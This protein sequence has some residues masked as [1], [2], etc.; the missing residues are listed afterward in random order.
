M[1]MTEADGPSISHLK[2]AK[3]IQEANQMKPVSNLLLLDLNA[4]NEFWCNSS[5]L[6]RILLLLLDYNFLGS[7]NDVSSYK[8]SF[9]FTMNVELLLLALN[10]GFSSY[11]NSNRNLQYCFF[12]M[13]V[14]IFLQRTTGSNLDFL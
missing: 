3:V 1:T 8:E 14:S 11:Y 2:H 7:R 5:S 6:Q 4:T 9:S 10:D 12:E 13:I